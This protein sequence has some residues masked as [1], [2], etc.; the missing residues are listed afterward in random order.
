[1]Y[2]CILCVCMQV[3]HKDASVELVGGADSLN[4]EL[5]NGKIFERLQLAGIP[6]LSQENYW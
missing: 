3:V 2:V 4:E 5:S 1:M 6:T